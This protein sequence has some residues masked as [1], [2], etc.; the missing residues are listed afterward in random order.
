MF[1]VAEP[2][3]NLEVR[4]NGAVLDAI[5]FAFIDNFDRVSQRLGHVGP[6][7][8]HLGS[9]LEPLLLGVAQTGWVVKIL[10]RIHAYQVIVRLGVLF[11]DKVHI[12]GGNQL[13]VVLVRHLDEPGVE[14]VLLDDTSGIVHGILRRMALKFKV[15]VVAEETLVPKDGLFCPF[16]VAVLELARHFAAQTGRAADQPFVIL[17]QH[18]MVDARTHIV[19]IHPADGYGLDQILVALLVLGQQDQVP[20][21]H[22]DLTFLSSQST[23]RHINFATE[24]RLDDGL[25]SLRTCL[26]FLGCYVE[27]VLNAEHIAVIGDGETRH[28]VG[29]SLSE[30]SADF[31]LPIEERKLCMYV[32]MC[33]RFHSL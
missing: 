15:V 6:K 23:M 8:V 4:H 25:S 21:A 22:I 11:I 13:D 14:F 29:G 18:L 1:L 2:S 10:A 31:T 27:K 30:E 20:A 24:D 9:G 3:G 16:Q 32:E 12:V 33:E 19:A 7:F 28:T 17:L 5:L 26:V